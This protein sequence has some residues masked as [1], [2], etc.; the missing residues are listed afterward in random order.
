MTKFEIRDFNLNAFEAMVWDYA[1]QQGIINYETWEKIVCESCK[2]T[3]ING[4][5]YMADGSKDNLGLN[6]KSV[7]KIPIAREEQVISFIQ[8]RSPID[9]EDAMN[10]VEI[11]ENIIETLVKKKQDSFDDLN[12]NKMIDVLIVHD[13][14]GDYYHTRVFCYEQSKYEDLDLVWKNGVGTLNGEK[15]WLMKRNTGS[16]SAFQ[17]CLMIKKS[18]KK[19]DCIVDLK[20][21]APNVALVNAEE[22]IQKYQN[23]KSSVPVG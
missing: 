19:I 3:W 21:Y 15:S 23:F 16:A 2:G 6:I 9:G 12:L 13:R 7:K 17:T 20:V 1:S 11:G 14:D 4:D 10:D 22:S 5:K 8:C 18:Y